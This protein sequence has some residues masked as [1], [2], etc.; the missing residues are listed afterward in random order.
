MQL[1]TLF[2]AGF[3]AA[4]AVASEVDTNLGSF[5]GASVPSEEHLMKANAILQ[6]RTPFNTEKRAATINVVVHVVSVDDTIRGGNV[7]VCYT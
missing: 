5:C 3:V 7:P 2:L 1:K 6:Q 4:A